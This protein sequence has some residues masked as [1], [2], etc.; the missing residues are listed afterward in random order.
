MNDGMRIIEGVRRKDRV[1][2]HELRKKTNVPTVNQMAAQAIITDAWKIAHNC[3]VAGLEDI[4]TQLNEAGMK[5]REKRT[6]TLTL[7]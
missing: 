2:I 4:F 3:K 1:S 5:T 7:F 6:A